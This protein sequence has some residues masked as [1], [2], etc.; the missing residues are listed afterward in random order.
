MPLPSEG[1]TEIT[2]LETLQSTTA[3]EMRAFEEE[4][5]SST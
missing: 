5:Q 4:M 1:G 3:M 2:A